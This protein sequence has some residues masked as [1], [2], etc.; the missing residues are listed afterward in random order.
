LDLLILALAEDSDPLR[1][2]ASVAKAWAA[3]W[4]VRPC[5]LL[6]NHPLTLSSPPLNEVLH[7]TL[8]RDPAAL[9]FFQDRPWERMGLFRQLAPSCVCCA[10]QG[11]LGLVLAGMYRALKVFTANTEAAGEMAKG[12]GAPSV[13]V[14]ASDDYPGGSAKPTDLA[15]LLVSTPQISLGKLGRGLRHLTPPV[16]LVPI[17]SLSQAH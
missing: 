2:Q 11:Q 8:A 3:Q 15:V 9:G 1:F 16:R 10:Q 14:G 7:Q 12:D 4:S 5:G 13:G 17:T 6:L